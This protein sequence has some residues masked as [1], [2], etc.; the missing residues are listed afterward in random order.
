MTTGYTEDSL[1][2][3][4]KGDKSHFFCS[5]VRKLNPGIADEAVNF[6]VEELTNEDIV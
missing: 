6:A 5:T 4:E 1:V 2:E 3:G